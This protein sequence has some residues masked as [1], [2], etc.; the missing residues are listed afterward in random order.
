[1]KIVQQREYPQAPEH[2]WEALTRAEAIRQWWLDTDFEPTVGHRFEFRD[3]PQGSWD[4]RAVGE[5]LEAD[6][7]HRVVFTWKGGGIDTVVE[8]LLEP[9]ET[10]GTRFTLRHTGFRGASGLLMAAVL[11]LG[12]RGY[13][14]KDVPDYAAHVAEHGPDAAYPKPTKAARASAK[15]RG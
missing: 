4:G 7:P 12:W 11:R 1:M 13:L 15:Q 5:V 3:T 8:Y 10:G 2:V 6:A 9:T 14:R